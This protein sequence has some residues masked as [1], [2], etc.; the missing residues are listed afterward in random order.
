MVFSAPLEARLWVALMALLTAEFAH[1]LQTET[2]A[3]APCAEIAASARRRR[4]RAE[5]I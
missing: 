2:R 5:R 4:A 1:Q 3:H